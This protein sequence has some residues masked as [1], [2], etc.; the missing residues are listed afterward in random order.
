MR[1]STTQ[2]KERRIA[3]VGS[4]FGGLAAAIRLQAAGMRVTIFEARDLPGG[5]AYVYRDKG[6]TFDAGPTV[7]TAP[8]CLEE[9]FN[10]GGVRM[11]DRVEMLPVTPFY[12][13]V[14]DDGDTMDYDGDLAGAIGRRSESDAEGYRRF[15]E[16]SREVF[17]TGYVELA[18]VP[19]L[20]FI[21]MVRCAPDLVRLG[22]H[23]SVYSMVAKYVKDEHVRQALSFH[24]LL[25]GG[26]P[27]D[28]SAI[29]TL[30]HYLERKWGVWFPR[31]G[32]GALVR[33]LVKLF[34][35]LGGELR[36]STPVRSIEL[37]GGAHLVTTDAMDREPF[38]A[39]VSNA[40]L[41]HTYGKLYAGNAAAASTTRKLERADW[42]MSLFVLYFG[43]DTPYDHLAHHTV[44]F[45]PRYKELLREIF[46]GPNL[47][48]DFSLY[49]HA[50]TVTDP[51]LAPPGCGS[52][53]VLSPVPHLGNANVDWA[54]EGEAYADKILAALE[55]HMP[56]LRRHV[57]TKRWFTPNDFQSQLA[58]YQGAAFSLAPKLQQSAWFRP[59]N[60]D[61]KIPGLYIVGAGTHPGAG[62]PGV[63]GSAKATAS[64]VLRDFGMETTRIVLPEAAE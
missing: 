19:F 64:V 32:T 24:S 14:W 45:G 55:R 51:S 46:D 43:T 50:P 15:V 5:R 37:E 25:V 53:Y 1:D 10:L 31:G 26:N 11:R 38:D 27:F 44:I 28:T 13:L 30:I 23:R 41:H 47:P 60:R 36:L 58:A 61:P 54:N 16:Y 3:V 4:G 6:F 62:V 35:E 17:E 33:A 2:E 8:E 56:D 59:H 52:F 18:H 29:Y 42:S 22:A 12:R 34:E 21:D 57:V 39:V 9:L 49:L 63:V 40:D 7:I 20:R 48:D